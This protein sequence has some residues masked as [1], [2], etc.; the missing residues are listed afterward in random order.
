MRG[1]AAWLIKQVLPVE[2]FDF[3]VAS[4]DD[5]HAARSTPDPRMLAIRTAADCNACGDA[6]LAQLGRQSG[7]GVRSIVASGGCV[8][9]LVENGQVLAQLTMDL[10]APVAVETPIPLRVSLPEKAGFLSYLYTYPAWRGK[11]L[12]QH[13]IRSAVHDLGK[14]GISQVVAHVSTTNVNSQ[15]AFLGTGWRRSG[16]MVT[17]R[18][19]R[20]LYSGPGLAARG[21]TLTA[22]AVR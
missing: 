14:S 2:I 9:A 17:D 10:R 22:R 16:L 21:I 3:F 20:V 7:H 8:Y 13:L 6:L 1:T 18:N 4:I 19:S 5:L 12:A 11:G 15:N